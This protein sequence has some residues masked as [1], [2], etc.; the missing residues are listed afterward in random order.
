[1][2][3][4]S[5]S[6][7][8]ATNF[9]SLVFIIRRRTRNFIF[10][11]QHLIYYTKIWVFQYFLLYAYIEIQYEI[12]QFSSP[13]KLVEKYLYCQRSALSSYGRQSF[14][15]L[16]FLLRWSE[17]SLVNYLRKSATVCIYECICSTALSWGLCSKHAQIFY[18]LS[19]VKR[20]Y[21][22]SVEISILSHK[23]KNLAPVHFCW[24]REKFVVKFIRN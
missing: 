15:L 3:T 9:S 17:N 16:T 24:F 1:M 14:I 20:A 5:R 11:K 13:Q 21:G 4:C 22:A 7:I 8:F 18:S 2:Q 10:G 23:F 6:Q 12:S 19:I